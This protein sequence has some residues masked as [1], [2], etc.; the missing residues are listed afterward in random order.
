MDRYTEH[1]P[2]KCCCF[3]LKSK[4]NKGCQAIFAVLLG[5][6]TEIL[7]DW[8]FLSITRKCY[9]LPCSTADVSPNSARKLSIAR[10]LS[11]STSSVSLSCFALSL[12]NTNTTFELCADA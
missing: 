2:C 5:I 4:K 1:V 11:L 6:I 3:Y 9:L 12:A 8:Q 10:S 7:M